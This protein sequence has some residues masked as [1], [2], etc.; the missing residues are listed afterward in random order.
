MPSREFF[1]V[2]CL[3]QKAVCEEAQANKATKELHINLIMKRRLPR[4]M[5]TPRVGELRQSCPEEEKNQ[6]LSSRAYA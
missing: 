4:R 2:R 1:L 6:S 3:N 5:I